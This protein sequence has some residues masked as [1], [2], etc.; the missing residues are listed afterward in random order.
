M[1]TAFINLNSVRLL[2]IVISFVLTTTAS[3]ADTHQ[4]IEK[5]ELLMEISGLNDAA[6]S[7]A[8]SLEANVDQSFSNYGI[9]DP[10]DPESV[11]F[12]YE[13]KSSTHELLDP[14]LAKQTVINSML[15]STSEQHID[16]AIQFYES[17]TGQ[18]IKKISEASNEKMADPEFIADIQ[19][20][21]TSNKDQKLWDL[22]QL[23]VNRS[24]LVETITD[25]NIDAEIAT[26][27]GIAELI[28]LELAELTGLDQYIN[29]A[30][31]EMES[32]REPSYAS[33][34]PFVNLLQ[35]H[36]LSQLSEDEIAEFE[37]F[38]HSEAAEETTATGFLGLKQFTIS[39]FFD[40]GMRIA[41]YMNNTEVTEAAE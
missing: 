2:A 9:Y 17:P 32:A 7:I 39:A 22:S 21:D 19:S 20:L 40:L 38:I 37:G 12:Y 25:I 13:T 29:G 24:K 31:Q 28:D 10:E 15:D 16:V 27:Y 26:L 14:K 11:E 34:K 35:Y 41:E 23:T 18:K 5:I 6:E 8:E 4:R 3:Q 1:K 36:I 33:V 30:I